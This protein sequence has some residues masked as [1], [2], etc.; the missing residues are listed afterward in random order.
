MLV[1]FVSLRFFKVKLDG[2]RPNLPERYIRY[3]T[4][5]TRQAPHLE[6][7]TIHC[8][9][10]HPCCCKRVNENWVVCDEA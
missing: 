6:Y 9:K 1:A 7:F 3:I 10:S 2:F 5:T 4:K 8:V